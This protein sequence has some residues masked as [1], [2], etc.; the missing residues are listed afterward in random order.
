MCVCV[1]VCVCACVIWSHVMGMGYLKFMLSLPNTR[2]LV[3]YM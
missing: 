2:K 3:L 1:C